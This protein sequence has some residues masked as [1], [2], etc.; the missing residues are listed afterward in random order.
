MMVAAPI[1]IE[2][3][4]DLQP[5]EWE[6]F[7]GTVGAE[8]VA[9]LKER[10]EPENNDWPQTHFP[11]IAEFVADLDDGHVR[12]R[13][14]TEEHQTGVGTGHLRNTIWHDISQAWAGNSVGDGEI[15]LGFAAPY[16][17]RFHFGGTSIVEID[18]RGLRRAYATQP[19][20]R[21]FIKKHRLG[22]LFAK[23]SFTMTQGARP[24]WDDWHLRDIVYHAARD[25][26][27]ELNP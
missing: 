20:V 23:T 9:Y 17:E 21:E 13:S 27:P 2:V 22:W 4:P 26:W 8:F 11:R 3:P 1:D 16:A 19:R 25:R 18:Q 6:E 24:L 12:D 5:E 14:M 7:L 15:T 10:F